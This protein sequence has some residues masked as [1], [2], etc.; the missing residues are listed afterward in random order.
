MRLPNRRSALSRQCRSVAAVALAVASGAAAAGDPEA[1][2]DAEGVRDIELSLPQAVR[3]A[4][5]DNP[6]LIDARLS[7]RVQ[8]FDLAQAE[9][10]FVPELSFGILSVEQTA[11]LGEDA[12]LYRLGAGPG[13]LLRLPTGGTVDVSPSWS[14]FLDE[15]GQTVSDGASV[16][17]RLR[18][19]LLRGGGPTVG[20]APVRLARMAEAGHMLNFEAA[21]MDIVTAVI[22]RYRAVIEAER[23]EAIN[24]GALDRTRNTL[25]VNRALID[26]GRMADTAIAET[27]AEVARRE[28]ALIRSQDRRDDAHR[29]LN[30]MLNLDAG[31]R[32]IA[33]EQATVDAHAAPPDLQAVLAL[34][35]AGHTA[36]RRALLN[37]ERAELGVA[38]AENDMLW[39]V[40]LTADVEL[41]R[42]GSPDDLR[43]GLA[44]DLT[45][46]YTVG[47]ALS[48]PV[49]D[50]A[51]KARRRARLVAQTAAR[52]AEQALASTLR[53]METGVLNGVRAIRVGLRQVELAQRALELAAEKLEVEQEKL[54][55]GFSTNFRVTQ[56]QADLVQA[57]VSDLNARIGYLNAVAALD[58]TVGGTLATWDID[59]ERLQE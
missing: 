59:I 32:V 1:G 50:A 21:T 45:R 2:D 54:R 51:A 26:T 44:R 43:G 49:G 20:A 27:E 28:L 58:R 17:F 14:V 9:N 4:L 34:A 6:T 15:S 24:R 56:F 55:L 23:R 19:P 53:E 38:L 36:Y 8:R 41:R 52:Q 16:R 10:W 47:V 3:R 18:Q 40:S 46:P 30:I 11:D 13:V 25:A 5:Q 42:T 37:L 22:Y 39:D 29:D 12:E 35:Q 48:V 31:T 33:T 7:R 57:Q